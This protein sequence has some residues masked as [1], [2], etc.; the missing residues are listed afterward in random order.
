M[1]Y[2]GDWGVGVSQHLSSSQLPYSKMKGLET[3]GQIEV[4]YGHGNTTQNGLCGP[5]IAAWL[6]PQRFLEIQ[7]PSQGLPP[8]IQPLARAELPASDS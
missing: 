5:S 4:T 2:L 7:F 8:M 6:A 1:L 3:E